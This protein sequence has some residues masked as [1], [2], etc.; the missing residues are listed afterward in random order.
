[1][2]TK[3][4]VAVGALVLVAVTAIWFLLPVREWIEGFQGWITDLGAIGIAVFVALYV[5]VTVV[6]GPAWAL[7]LVAGLAYGLWGIPLVIGSATLAACVAFLIG[8]HVARERVKKLVDDNGKLNALNRA[9]SK[10]GWKVVGLMRLSP[11]F[12]FGLQ[13]YLFGVTGIGFLPYALATAIGILPGTALY[14][15]IGS[16]GNAG[17]EGGGGV[18]LGAARGGS[19]RDLRRRL[20]RDETGKVGTR[21][22]RSRLT[23]AP[24]VARGACYRRRSGPRRR[25]RFP[26]TER[27]TPDDPYRN[28]TRRRR[29][30]RG[31]GGVQRR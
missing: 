29:P 19:R 30:V 24:R 4:K 17:G 8:R 7:T 18:S 16:L 13:N 12:P 31:A 20:A 23:H 6:L 15:Y 26:I 9:V 1:M 22:A 21:A 5:G 3:M 10:E 11:V 27:A 2:S 25:G 28:R 14:V